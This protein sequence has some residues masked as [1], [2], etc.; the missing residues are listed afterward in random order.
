MPQELKLAL[1]Q[2]AI[3]RREGVGQGR[4]SAEDRRGWR[5]KGRE[6]RPTQGWAV[7]WGKKRR[8]RK[9]KKTRKLKGKGEGGWSRPAPRP[10]ARHPP[11]EG[12]LT[13]VPWQRKAEMQSF[14]RSV[15]EA[16]TI[17]SSRPPAMT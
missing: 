12:G 5:G 16:Q 13:T 4:E 6:G 9:E 1:E 17:H 15:D 7:K 11:A 8:G 2:N 10:G 14:Q 3:E